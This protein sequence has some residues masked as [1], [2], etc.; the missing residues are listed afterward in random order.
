V[1]YATDSGADLVILGTRG[2]TNLR[3]VLLGSTAEHVVQDAQ[4]SVLVTKPVT[5]PVISP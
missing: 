3:D 1:K 2:K 4:C 5:K